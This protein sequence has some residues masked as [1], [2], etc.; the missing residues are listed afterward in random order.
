MK[1]Y[2]PYLAMNDHCPWVP[3]WEH[4]LCC[5]PATGG[6]RVIM[7]RINIRPV[8]CLAKRSIPLNILSNSQTREQ[9]IYPIK[10]LNSITMNLLSRIALLSFAIVT[11]QS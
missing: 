6:H 7:Q 1:K 4:N 11:I 8:V 2:D 3:A 9:Q 10:D 5:I